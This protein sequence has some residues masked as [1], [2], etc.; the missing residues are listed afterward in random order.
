MKVDVYISR[1]CQQREVEKKRVF[2]SSRVAAV[3]TKRWSRDTT[4]KSCLGSKWISTTRVG[5]S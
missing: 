5:S 2:H 4:P 3:A 1:R